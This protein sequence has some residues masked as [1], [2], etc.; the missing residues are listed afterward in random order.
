MPCIDNENNL[1][2]NALGVRIQRVCPRGQ[3]CCARR[4]T[5]VGAVAI[6][7]RAGITLPFGSVVVIARILVS[8][9]TIVYSSD[10]TLLAVQRYVGRCRHCF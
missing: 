2:N 9:T 8:I 5:S 3:A 6:G 4:L 1:P 7:A 10:R